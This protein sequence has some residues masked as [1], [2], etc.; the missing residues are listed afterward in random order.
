MEAVK[1]YYGE[2]SLYFL[3]HETMGKLTR[4]Y[5]KLMFVDEDLLERLLAKGYHQDLDEAKLIAWNTAEEKIEYSKMSVQDN[6]RFVRRVYYFAK[7][8]YRLQ[9]DSYNLSVVNDRQILGSATIPR[10]TA[11]EAPMAELKEKAWAAAAKY[12]RK[13]L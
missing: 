10:E 5:V 3:V 13:N 12:V 6:K 1:A 8:R 2:E 9:R 7:T 11:P 4:Y